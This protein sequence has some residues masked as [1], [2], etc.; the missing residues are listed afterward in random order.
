MD[1]R[2]VVPSDKHDLAAVRAAAA[3]GWPGIE[4]VVDDL[5]AWMQDG[6]WPVEPAVA[7]LLSGVGSPLA[8]YVRP[9]LT[10]DD[11]LWGYWVVRDVL[12]HSPELALALAGELRHIAAFPPSGEGGAELALAAAEVLAAVDVP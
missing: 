8:P 4:P 12:A 5:L 6:N 2:H 3:L 10:G 9:I 7:R 1:L 11:D